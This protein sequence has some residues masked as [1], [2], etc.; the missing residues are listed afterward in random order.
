MATEILPRRIRIALLSPAEKAICEAVQ[1]VDSMPAD[2]Q[3]TWALAL[4]SEAR[5]AVADYIDGVG[6]IE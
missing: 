5:D 3:L 1:V 6:A 2:A 4:L